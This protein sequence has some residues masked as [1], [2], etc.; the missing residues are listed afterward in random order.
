MASPSWH[1]SRECLGGAPFLGVPLQLSAPHAPKHIS[2][3]TTSGGASAMCSYRS[4]S[5]TTLVVYSIICSK[6]EVLKL[7]IELW[8][9]WN[10]FAPTTKGV[11]SKTHTIETLKYYFLRCFN[12][13]SEEIMFNPFSICGRG[14]AW[15]QLAWLGAHLD[16]GNRY[17]KLLQRVA[18]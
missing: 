6:L 9:D 4:L 15:P 13:T 5:H 17:S 14:S 11:H 12:E 3:G 16:L 10:N 1:F 8:G 2:T 18:L 7:E